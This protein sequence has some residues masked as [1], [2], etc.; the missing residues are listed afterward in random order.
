MP[1]AACQSNV[2]TRGTSY[3]W[4]QAVLSCAAVQ[5]LLCTAMPAMLSAQQRASYHFWVR[6]RVDA[7]LAKIKG[8]LMYFALRYPFWNARLAMHKADFQSK[9]S[10]THLLLLVLLHRLGLT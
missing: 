5:N 6:M 8:L 4:L 10:L 9:D 2:S 3:I 1:A 7:G